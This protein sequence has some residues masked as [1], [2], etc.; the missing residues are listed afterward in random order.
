MPKKGVARDPNW[1]SRWDANSE[2][3]VQVEK[4]FIDIEIEFFPNKYSAANFY[5]SR[6]AF[7]RYCSPTKF[8]NN[9]RE[10][11]EKLKG[12]GYSKEK[13][14]KEETDLKMPKSKYFLLSHFISFKNVLT[15][16]QIFLL[17]IFHHLILTLNQ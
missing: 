16:L 1:I 13:I 11:A 14:R 15:Y 5:K 6:K 17:A 3:A 7:L 9:I 10:I 8:C 4:D 12:S 2:V